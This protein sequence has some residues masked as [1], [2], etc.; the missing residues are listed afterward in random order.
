L[1]I[2]EHRLV[3]FGHRIR[4]RRLA[5][6][7]SVR[8][9]AGMTGVSPSYISAI[10][11]AR[12]STTG[13]APEPSIGI[14]HRLL[15]ALEL[16]PTHFARLSENDDRTDACNHLLLYR[17]GMHRGPLKPMLDQ[18]FDDSVDQWFC[19]ADP[20]GVPEDGA[21]M[22][23]W[24]WAF[25]A[26]PYPDDYLEPAR[27]LESLEI[28]LKKYADRV[29]PRRSGLLTADCS[30]VMRWVVNPESEVDFETGWAELSGDVVKRVF[31][32]A[33]V[34]NVCVYDHSDIESLSTRIDILDT[35]MRL[36]T[37]H[38]NVAAIDPENRILKGSAAIAAI[39]RECKPG[40]VSSTGW[41]S[42]TSAAAVTFARDRSAWEIGRSVLVGRE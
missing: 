5:L 41:R 1:A 37:S 13:R 22:I 10:E 12:N 35:L 38:T 9:L 8:A 2:D 20:R 16:P 21:D 27:I 26:N 17:L 4:E 30:T 25:G 40:G 39:L 23:S 24:L 29:S 18:L 7:L 36:F 34:A 42:L 28:E 32:R 33:P 14:A 3:D 15:S 19:I 31:G 11:T 6:R